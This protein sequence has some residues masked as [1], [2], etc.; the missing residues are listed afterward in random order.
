MNDSPGRDRLLTSVSRPGTGTRG[1]ITA[2]VLLAVVGFAGVVQVQSNQ[3]DD[4]YEGMREEDLVQLLNSLASASQRA[5]NDIAQLEQTRSSLR[6]DTDSR[7]AVLEQAR[8][9]AAVLG[10]L[11]GTLPAVGPGIV[12]TVEDPEQKVG[13]DQMLN[14]IQ[15]LRD[16]G[17]EAMEINNTVR[18][19]S[20][21]AL[22]DGDEGIVVDGT[23]LAPPYMIEVIGDSHTLSQ[24]LNFTGGFVEDIQGPTVG[25]SVV[26]EQSSNVEVAAL[27][28]P[29]QPEYADPV[30]P[31]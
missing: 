31:E 19:V 8:Q 18:V 11:A 3:R 29:R 24:A 23:E 25:G 12:V 26:I 1:Q 16:S 22:E 28:V 6:S 21:T 27:A 2:A 9:R 5:E 30:E 17:A 15:E 14:G 10:I 13:I 7:Q 4:D 20:Q